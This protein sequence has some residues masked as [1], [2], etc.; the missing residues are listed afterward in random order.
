MSALSII[1]KNKEYRKVYSQGKP[2]AD[3]YMVIYVL[4]NNL[5][6]RRFGFTVSKKI[7]KAVKRN[8]I[9]RVFKEVCRLNLKNF[10][11]GFDYIIIARHDIVNLSF[12]QIEE[13]LLRLLKKASVNR[14]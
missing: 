2:Y 3:R 14:R 4:R 10:P 7:G 6:I 11:E 8:R 13:R 5:G 1:K 9:R 12:R